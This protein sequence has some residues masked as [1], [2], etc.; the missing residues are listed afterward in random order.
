MRKVVTFNNISKETKI[1]TYN[2]RQMRVMILT[3]L[4][5]TEFLEMEIQ[6]WNQNPN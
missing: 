1:I 3:A 2:L 4:W 6:K 5:G